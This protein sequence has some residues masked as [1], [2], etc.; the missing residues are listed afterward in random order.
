MNSP[1]NER[2]A[3]FKWRPQETGIKT[4]LF[5]TEG[6][7]LAYDDTGGSGSLIVMVPGMGDLRQEYRFLVEPLRQEGYRVVTLDIRGHG[8]SSSDW[9]EYSRVAVGRDILALIKHLQAG[10][11]HLFGTS[12]AAG[13]AIWAA[14]EEPTA[15]KGLVLIGPFVRKVPIDFFSQITLGLLLSGPWKVGAW[16]MYFDSLFPSRKPADY[17]AYRAALAANLRQPGRFAALKAFMYSPVE[18]I[19]QR[20]GRVKVP[21]LVLMGSKDRDFKNPKAEAAWVA[22]NVGGRYC[23]VE[24]AGHYPYAEMPEVVLPEIQALLTA[25]P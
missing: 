14:S 23:M 9:K 21:T 25:S 7:G 19:E 4:Q 2:L 5:A 3:H 1:W 13:S 16:I 17:A 24:G 22:Q 11:A 20:L 10:P 12:F 15:V 18:E 6:G 8:E